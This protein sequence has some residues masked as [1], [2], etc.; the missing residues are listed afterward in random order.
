MLG[1]NVYGIVVFAQAIIAYFNVLVSFGFNIS[2]TNLISIHRD[3]RN[4]LSEIVSSTLIIK[5]A[6]SVLSLIILVLIMPYLP[7]S[8]TNEL[9]FYLTFWICVYEVIFPSWYFQGIEKMGYITL[10]TLIARL[11][12]LIFIFVLITE[13]A[14]YLFVPIINGIGA[15]ITGF[16]ALYI[17]FV[18]HKVEFRLQSLD[19]L[20]YYFKDSIP[21]FLSNFSSKIYVTSN[22]VIVGSFLGLSEVA[23]YDLAEKVVNIAKIPQ[24]ILSQSIFPKISKEKNTD[25]VRK[26]FGISLFVNCLIVGCIFIFAEWIVLLLG[27]EQM[28]DASKILILLSLTVPVIAA[29]NIFGIQLLIPFGHKK[30]F[31]G[32]I[33]ISGAVYLILCLIVWLTIGFTVYNIIYVTIITELIV[34]S[35]MFYYTKKLKLWK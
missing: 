5:I 2:A 3:D 6:L 13:K 29:S 12:F 21:I 7:N 1:A 25:F 17:V 8:E 10:L 9:L 14:D 30:T 18:K 35:V 11:F 33:I 31:T 19:T 20:A 27:G 4:K 28:M 26:I 24:T 15:L 23:F 22:K 34:A 16:V 32:I